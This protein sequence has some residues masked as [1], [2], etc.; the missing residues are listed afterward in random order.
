MA[1]VPSLRRFIIALAALAVPSPAAVHADG[2]FAAI[3]I[4][5]KNGPSNWGYSVN[6]DSQDNAEKLA[7]QKCNAPDAKVVVWSHD[8]WCALAVGD[9]NGWGSGFGKTQEDG[10]KA[11][12]DEAAKH[13]KNPHV[14][15]AV[16]SEG[17]S[18]EKN[19]VAG[20]G[21]HF[22]AIAFSDK[23]GAWGYSYGQ[24]SRQ[25]AEAR[26]VLNSDPDGK[27]V[28]QVRNGWCALAAGDDGVHGW[29]S[30]ASDDEA[31]KAALD[32]AG[33][34]SKNPRVSFAVSSEGDVIWKK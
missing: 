23:S 21:D 18:V 20:T 1:P 12:L 31:E 27:A 10:R 9:D 8:G 34:R 28:V 16:S 4:S 14:I 29:G 32:D 3:A 6:Q 15:L 5:D 17:E 30:G 13:T 26:A 24:P 7:I 2:K 33:K 25:F 11:A 19:P 22:A